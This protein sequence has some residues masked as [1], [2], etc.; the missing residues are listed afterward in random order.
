M[1]ETPA[2][3][4]PAQTANVELKGVDVS[5]WNGNINWQ[6][7]KA[8]GIDFAIIRAG[9]G[10]NNID[11]WFKT[12]AKNAV[13]AGVDVGFYWFSYAVNA[14]E[15]KAEADYLCDAVESLGIKPTYPLCYDYEYDSV[16]KAKAKGYNPTNAEITA[17][18]EAF[19]S[20]IVARGYKAA[21]YTNIDFLN[22]GFSA[23]TSTY[24]TWLAQWSVSKPTKDC[25]LWQYSDQGKVDGISG[26]VDVN[27]SFKDYADSVTTKPATTATTSAAA[28]YT[29]LE[30]GS[31][32]STV[33]ELQTKLNALGYNC[34]TVDGNFGA[35]TMAAVKAFQK[36]N[37]LTVDGIV[38][39]QT[40][41]AINGGSTVASTTVSNA[42]SHATVRYGSTGADVAALQTI[43]NSNGYNCG[44]VDGDFGV[45]TLGAVKKY[46]KAKGLTVDGIVGPQTWSALGVY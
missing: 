13:A 11:S 7:V 22:K 39:S 14:T 16:D 19:L 28:T 23:L 44:K 33:K 21:N 36:A 10:K 35:K 1:G 46:Q 38:G 9:Y 4:A 12:N 32:G 40:L 15:A 27:I 45:K 26:V 6:K 24:D 30:Y 3:K 31:T 34:G 43:L 8:A 29:T 2:V 5:T 37:N 41:G 18:A 20:E 17:M 42:T 25:T